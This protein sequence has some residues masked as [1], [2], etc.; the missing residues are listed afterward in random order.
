MV[1]VY[2]FVK[3]PFLKI[4]FGGKHILLLLR[5][6][7]VVLIFML[8]LLFRYLKIKLGGRGRKY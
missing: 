5:L 1:L 4:M 2:A 3:L 8:N 6:I 7:Y